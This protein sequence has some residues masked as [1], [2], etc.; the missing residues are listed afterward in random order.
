MWEVCEALEMPVNF[1]IGASEQSMDWV[2]L[3]GWPGL[4]KDL[5][6]DLVRQKAFIVGAFIV[7]FW[8]LAAIFGSLFVQDPLAQNLSAIN[9]A[10]SMRRRGM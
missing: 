2:G 8:I 3:Q 7:G 9:Q 6:R 1:H 4:H 5:L 10:P